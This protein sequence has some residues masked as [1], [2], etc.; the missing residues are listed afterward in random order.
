MVSIYIY[1]GIYIYTNIHIRV[2]ASL[3][4]PPPIS[5]GKGL[6]G[7]RG[8]GSCVWGVLSAG[9]SKSVMLIYPVPLKQTIAQLQCVVVCCRVLQ[10]VAGCCSVWQCVA[11]CCSV[12]Q[13]VAVCCRVFRVLQGVAVCC[14]V[15]QWVSLV[16][17]K[18]PRPPALLS[19][20]GSVV[21]ETHVCG[22]V[23]GIWLRNMYI[24][25]RWTCRMRLR[26]RTV[27]NTA[28]CSVLQ[29]VAVCHN[30]SQ[31]VTVCHSVLQCVAIGWG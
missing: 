2:V 27:F 20:W 16:L 7:V 22:G 4:L 21:G 13:C 1:D 29:C 18:Y 8:G 12:W 26:L 28:C 23:G 6:P 25:V 31:C 11:G 24:E 19:R 15:L 10:C 14:S 30:V 9:Y 5:K 3:S 17:S